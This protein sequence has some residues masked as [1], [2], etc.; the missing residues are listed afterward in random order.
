LRAAESDTLKCA[1]LVLA[2][3]KELARTGTSSPESL[4][5]P[6]GVDYQHFASV[7]DVIAE[8]SLAKLPKPRIGFF[9]LIYEK[10]DFELLSAVACLLDPASL[11]CIGPVDYCPASFRQLPNVHLLGSKPYAEL[12]GWLAGLDVLLLPYVQDEMIRQ[13]RPLKLLE[14]LATGRPTVSVDI[15]EVRAFEPHVRVART[16]AEFIEAVRKA[17]HESES[18]SMRVSRQQAVRAEGWNCRAEQLDQLLRKV[19]EGYPGSAPTQPDPA[20]LN[21][22][23][24]ANA[25]A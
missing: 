22:V 25:I 20:G 13:S 14:C 24:K 5:F 9:G 19:R 4:Y 10:L 7:Q 11:V 21:F 6:H 18:D 8:P 12:P 3:S 1:R 15:P 2:A 16:T 17:V 23:S